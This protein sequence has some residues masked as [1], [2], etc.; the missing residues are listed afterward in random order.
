MPPSTP[1]STDRTKKKVVAVPTTRR[2]RASLR[3][4]TAWPIR[5]LAAMVTPNA[6][7]CIMKKIWAALLVAV[8]PVSPSTRLTQNMLAVMF[9]D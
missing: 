6:A 4:P 8:T 5:M 7:P 1:I 2:A 9:M 3:A